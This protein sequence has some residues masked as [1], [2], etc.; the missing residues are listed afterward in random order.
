MGEVVIPSWKQYLA[1]VYDP[2]TETVTTAYVNPDDAKGLRRFSTPGRSSW[3]ELRPPVD[4]SENA[5]TYLECRLNLSKLGWEI[6]TRRK[7]GLIDYIW[8]GKIP[9]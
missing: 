4:S 1:I 8:V 3:V 9:I 2:S 7:L 6:W 5:P